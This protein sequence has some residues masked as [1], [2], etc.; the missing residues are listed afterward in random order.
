KRAPERITTRPSRIATTPNLLLERDDLRAHASGNPYVAP[1]P[2]DVAFGNSHGRTATRR[3]STHLRNLGCRRISITAIL[4]ESR[5]H[6]GGRRTFRYSDTKRR[7]GLSTGPWADP[8]R[9]R[10]SKDA[11]S[12]RVRVQYK[13]DDLHR[14]T[15][16][17]SMEN[18]ERF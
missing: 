6:P 11:R 4:G 10:R 3:A 2:R 16:R 13:D 14:P 8:R 15:K 9:R 5:L 17:F 1:M 12:H 7:D 18:R